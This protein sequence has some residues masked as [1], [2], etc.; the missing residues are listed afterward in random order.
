M[1]IN[2]IARSRVQSLV[3]DN[4]SLERIIGNEVE[5]FANDAET[6]IGTIAHDA[7]LDHW[8]YVLL[9]KAGTG[10]YHALAIETG[11]VSQDEATVRLLRAMKAHEEDQPTPAQ[12]FQ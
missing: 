3:A 11:L 6:L 5:W 4:P 8:T 10:S 7:A 2:T 9:G 12:H 1:S